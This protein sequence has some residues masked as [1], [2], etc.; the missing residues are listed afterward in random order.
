MTH[1]PYTANWQRCVECGRP[2]DGT[3][4]YCRECGPGHDDHTSQCDCC[5]QMKLDCQP[6][7]LNYVGDTW[8]CPKCSGRD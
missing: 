7:W 1:K 5:G 8:A 4:N 6:V 3:S 2:T